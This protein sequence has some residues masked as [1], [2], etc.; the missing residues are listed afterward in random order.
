MA[1]PLMEKNEEDADVEAGMEN[2][3]KWPGRLVQGGEM[4]ATEN[5]VLTEGDE[6]WQMA[7]GENG[8]PMG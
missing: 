5:E 7:E 3:E 6:V 1:L 2:E 4:P 8:L